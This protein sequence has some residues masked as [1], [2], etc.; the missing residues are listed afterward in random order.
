MKGFFL[1]ILSLITACKAC[2]MVN[3]LNKE[4]V[5][6]KCNPKTNHKYQTTE[7]K[8]YGRIKL[9]KNLTVEIKHKNSKTP[10]CNKGFKHLPGLEE[11][12]F[13]YENGCPKP[14]IQTA[15]KTAKTTIRC[16][17]SKK[18]E[19]SFFCKE[20]QSIC[21]DIVS[22]QSDR[23]LT[24]MNTS[25]GVDLYISNVSM[26]H[27]GFYWCGVKGKDKTYFLALTQLEVKNIVNFTKSTTTGQNLT[28]FCKYHEK[29]S[30]K[31]ICKGED[32]STCQCVLSTAK[33]D[34]SPRFSI[35]KKDTERKNISITMIKIKPED[36]G[37]YWCGEKTSNKQITFIHRMFLNVTNTK[38]T[39]S[40]TPPA[41]STH[42]STTTAQGTLDGSDVE[43]ALIVGALVLTLLL[44]M[45]VLI[46]AYKRFSRS[47]NTGNSAAEQQPKE[48]YIYEEVR[49][50]HR[51]PDSVNTIYTTC[52][53]ATSD[54]FSLHY[55]N[56][57]FKRNSA[58]AGES[59][60]LKPTSASC[61]YSTLKCNQSPTSL[62]VNTPS[63]STDEPFYST[64]QPRQKK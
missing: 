59:M 60:I 36:S 16:E 27:A 24:L 49:E 22:T 62:A 48:D 32:P 6:F 3:E 37:M 55:S 21:E 57:N 61:Q 14:V 42:A 26:N 41:P 18:Y 23:T 40:T 31:F 4:W 17:S 51:E 56:I 12:T 11:A 44:L 43:T 52:N 38:T 29:D 63:R 28:Y 33:P 1:L 13:Q 9:P 58:A 8:D 64:V 34:I 30:T 47:R 20:N 53:F 5:E 19:F 25:K 2:K 54:P 39:T 46:F 7:V 45:L 50:H 15:Y 35:T 10:R